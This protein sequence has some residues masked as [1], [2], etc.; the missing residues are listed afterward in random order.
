MEL[1]RYNKE[2]LAAIAEVQEMKK[3]PESYEGFNS[4]EDLFAELNADD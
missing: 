2:T 3:N 1:P 4:V